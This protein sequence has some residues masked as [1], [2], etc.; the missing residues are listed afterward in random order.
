L[1][2]RNPFFFHSISSATRQTLLIAGVFGLAAGG[3][4]NFLTLASLLA[5]V[6]LGVGGLFD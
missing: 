1:Y 2:A 3:S 6:G 4:P 5:V